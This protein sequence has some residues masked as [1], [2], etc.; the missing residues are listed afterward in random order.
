M[1]LTF[2]TVLQ[3]AK[4][5]GLRHKDVLMSSGPTRGYRFNRE[6]VKAKYISVLH[7][8]GIDY[9]LKVVVVHVKHVDPVVD[10]SNFGCVFRDGLND[11]GVGGFSDV[12]V[13]VRRLF[14]LLGLVIVRIGEAFAPRVVAIRVDRTGSIV[15]DAASLLG[16][17]V[18]L[19]GRF[20]LVQ[21]LRRAALGAATVVGVAVAPIVAAMAVVAAVAVL[22][23]LLTGNCAEGERLALWKRVTQVWGIPL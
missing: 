7:T 23:L 18:A 21:G 1:E 22:L 3:V 2:C 9:D 16:R 10:A 5:V 4:V 13:V 12:G 19:V 14:A 11:I 17:G 20:R 6:T 8:C 15:G